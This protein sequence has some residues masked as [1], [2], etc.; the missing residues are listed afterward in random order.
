MHSDISRRD[1]L[2]GV[3]VAIGASLLPAVS[4]GT[5]IA[6]QELSGYYPPALSGLR[7]SHPG[8]FEAAHAAINGKRWDEVG[9]DEEYDLVVV[10][11]GISGL[12]AAY[13]HR[14]MFGDDASI[15]ILENH[16][17]FGGHA[18]R[19]EFRIEGRTM[20]GYGGTQS[21]EAPAQFPEVATRLLRELGIDTQK[22]YAAYD[23]KLYSSLGLAPGVY[24]DRET[25]GR[26]HLA[27]GD[28]ADPATLAVLPLSDDARSDL[29]RLLADDSEYLAD[30]SG[31]ELDRY[32]KNTSYRDHLKN[33]VAIGEEVL[34]YM[35]TRSH[36][37]WATGIDVL[38]AYGAWH[39]GYP[40]FAGLESHT[41]IAD[42]DQEEPYIFH[43]PDGNASVARSLVRNMIPASAPGDSMEDVVTARFR[44][45]TLDVA[46][47]MV[48]IRLN[49]TAVRV[50]HIDDDIRK[51]VRVTYVRDNVARTVTAKRVVMACYHTMIPLM[52]PE[53]PAS[54]RA[55]LSNALRMPL[56]YTN[57]L[58]R[59]WTSFYKLGI[60][61]A[62]CPGSYHNSV[63]L[64]FP[65]SLGNYR[66]PKAPAEPM[67]LHLVR[68]PTKP[69][70]DGHEQIAAGQL[71]LLTTS[72]DTIEK[73]TR[74]QLGG[75]LSG[76]GFDPARD[77][78]AIT[79]NRWPHGYAVGYDPASSKLA[80]ETTIVP[81]ERRHW[82][83]ARE[84]FGNIAFAGTDAAS[85][86]Y[87]QVAIEQAHRAVSDLLT[88]R[89]I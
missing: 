30:L 43:F 74:E 8:S 17:D 28:L 6:A 71:E 78:A 31:D 40:G 25:F 50:R 15:L 58:I 89:R 63:S 80:L 23:R 38:P 68:V 32:L 60:S 45:N 47:S 41:A 2:N 18:K 72:F 35:Q 73:K 85:D 62:Y 27:A 57:V 44:Y 88:D 59:N 19:N 21:L 86:A 4:A 76:G 14:Q 29:R 77:I 12:A 39:S 67:V 75:M 79:V 54:Q 16:D 81:P 36:S 66:F 5:E 64:D 87:T 61:S 69:G 82:L 65:V 10:G 11:G 20:I 24:F 83:K 56:V 52:C 46:E 84:R 33:R 1:F 49:S 37:F 55:A 51:A 3:S 42:S 70:I 7:G 13:F 22:F 53:L 26:D 9:T 48:R 34:D